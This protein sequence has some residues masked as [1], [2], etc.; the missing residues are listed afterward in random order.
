M[1][2]PADGS[3][4][5]DSGFKQTS[6]NV[7]TSVFPVSFS[8]AACKFVTLSCS[9]ISSGQKFESRIGSNGTCFP[10]ISWW[11]KSA[12]DISWLQSGVGSKFDP[13][14]H[15]YVNHPFLVMNHILVSMMQLFVAFDKTVQ[16]IYC[17]SHI[18]YMI[19]ILSWSKAWSDRL[20]SQWKSIRTS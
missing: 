11:M 9:C 12:K 13:E 20:W 2:P 10:F 5:S 18:L 3:S 16:N 1:H 6:S 15:V 14:C 4:S 8:A 7:M 17:I 19:L